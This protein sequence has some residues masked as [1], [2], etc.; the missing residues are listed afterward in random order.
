[1]ITSL[2]NDKVR[3]VRALQSR[4][5]SREQEAALVVEGVRLCEE[6]V[7]AALVPRFALYTQAMETDSRAAPLLAV[8]KAAGVECCQVSEPVMAA[9]SDT[10]SPS[11]LLTVLPAPHLPLPTAPTL[12][13]V[14][15]RLRD[16][17]NLGTILRTA[18]AAG[19]DQ[20]LLASGTVDATNPKVMRAGAGAHFRLPIAALSW[21]AIAENVRCPVYLAAAGAQRSYTD[22]DWSAPSALIIGGEAAGP[23]PRAYDLAAEII[24]IPM[25]AGVESLNAAIASA[26]ILFEATRQRRRA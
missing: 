19:A 18:W 25:A 12:T 9:C 17:G 4:R 15:D 5:R 10:E 21:D 14:L 3:L 22:V 24:S 8:W 2:K 23:A 13:L 7:Q 20:V 16:P 26:V 6:A 11:G 1:M